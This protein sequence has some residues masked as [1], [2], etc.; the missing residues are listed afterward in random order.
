M[1][2]SKPGELTLAANA[3][4]AMSRARGLT[5][6][7]S[8]AGAMVLAP[9]VVAAA[10]AQKA[11]ECAP[12]A[13]RASDTEIY[14]S[15]LTHPSVRGDAKKAGLVV[16]RDIAPD[17]LGFKADAGTP[18]FFE[19]HMRT[20]N[21][22]LVERFLCVVG[23]QGRVPTALGRNRGMHLVSDAEL[24]RTLEGPGRDYW[25]EFSSRFP[26][27]AGVVRAS[28]VAYSTDGMEAM[29]YV[30]FAGGI[31]DAH[32]DAMVLRSVSGRWYVV[33]HVTTWS[34]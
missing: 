11:A 16:V 17:G 25:R 30:A 34:S 29:V 18:A 20:P 12:S 4:G 27:A 28:P 26:D 32:G 9:C 10:S 1:M 15:A 22:A 21:P 3:R 2:N 23:G 24:S 31:L 14:R 5:A 8:F 19:R 7:V 13:P 6:A 33:D